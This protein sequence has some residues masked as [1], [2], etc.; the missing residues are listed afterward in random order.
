MFSLAL[1]ACDK[2][3]EDPNPELPAP[4][5]PEASV[6]PL[7]GEWRLVKLEENGYEIK[8]ENCSR[9]SS[10]VFGAD[11][12]ATR[13]TYQYTPN[14]DPNDAKDACNYVVEAK[15]Y[16]TTLQQ[17]VLQSVA[18]STD[19][20]AYTYSLTTDT[21]VMVYTNRAGGVQTATYRK[22]YQ[23][24]PVKEIIGTWYIHSLWRNDIYNYD[25]DLTAFEGCRAQQKVVITKDSITMYQYRYTKNKCRE[26]VYK[27]AYEISAGLGIIKVRNKIRGKVNVGLREFRLG[28]GTLEFWGYV[29]G[30]AGDY[31]NEFYRKEKTFK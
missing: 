26:T 9:K 13:T 30:L 7:V 10:L 19:T 4:P 15:T 27:G 29:N 25:K 24:D 14:T 3:K 12:T 18:S 8:I 28:N 20:E 11:Q 17:L 1:A 22:N 16:T 5:K 21:L 2:Q 6:S 23:Y 31:E